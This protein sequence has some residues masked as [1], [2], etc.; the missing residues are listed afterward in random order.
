MTASKSATTLHFQLTCCC[1]WTSSSPSPPM[2]PRPSPTRADAALP[3]PAALPTGALDLRMQQ[4]APA[5]SACPELP[6]AAH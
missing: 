4:L 3:R 5:P 1:S 2:L 6:A